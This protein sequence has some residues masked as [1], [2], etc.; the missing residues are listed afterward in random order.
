MDIREQTRVAGRLVSSLR[1]GEIDRREFLQLAAFL[2]GAAVLAACTPGG[3]AKAGSVTIPLN[4]SENDPASL[5]FYAAAIASFQKLNPDI[6]IQVNIVQDA[7]SV[8]AYDTAF[9]NNTDLGIFLPQGEVVVSYILSNRLLPLTDMVDKI[10]ASDFIPASR[11]TVNG[12]DWGIPYQF[13]GYPLWYRTDLFQKAG[14]NPPNTYDD[15]L[16]AATELGGKN[17]SV[18]L[19]NSVSTSSTYAEQIGSPFIYQSGWDFYDR[20]GKV[21]FGQ[22]EVLAGVERLVALFKNTPN[23]ILTQASQGYLSAYTAGRAAMC[24]HGGKLGVSLAANAPQ[25]ADVTDVVGIPAG[26][27]MTGKL[28]YGLVG[29]YCIYAK[30]QHPT[31]AK[32]FLQ[33]LTTADSALAWSLTAPGHLLPPLISV[34]KLQSDMTNPL[35]AANA[36]MQKHFA[37]VQKITALIPGVGNPALDMGFVNNQE[38]IGQG[39]HPAPW[40]PQVWRAAPPVDANMYQ[41][42]LI[43]KQN[44]QQA[45]Q[46]AVSQ[47]TQAAQVWQSQNPTWKPI[48]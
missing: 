29:W 10:G 24:Q 16:A 17:G 6:Q 33:S 35:V 32:A 40:S 44:P 25:I 7:Q 28:V 43:S 19:A 23:A 34:Q 26:P 22:P 11:L 27:F 48:L 21:T 9:R 45:W 3:S 47:M 30:T 36:Y 46:N 15:M 38:V 4:T 12:Q 8:Q 37:W 18:G 2:S 5:K 39:F 41:Q 20:T 31:E 13:N 42:I 1:R 14:L